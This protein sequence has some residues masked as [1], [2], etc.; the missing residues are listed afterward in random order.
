M[1][2]RLAGILEDMKAASVAVVGDLMLDEYIIGDAE[3][4]SPEAPHP[5]IAERE[6]RSMPGGAAN[7]AVNATALGATVHLFGVIGGDPEGETLCRE[8][9]ARG[10]GTGGLLVMEGR[11]TTRKT[12][13]IAR[14]SQVL[15]VDRET[16]ESIGPEVERELLR[17]ILSAP[18][19]VVVVSD[20]A[21]GL[22]TPGLVSGLTVSGK[23][24]IV[25][26]KSA[27]FGR[28]ARAVLVTP[29]LHELHAAA[30]RKD[31]TPDTLDE[32]GRAIMDA[33]GIANLLVTLGPDGMALIER[34]KP[35]ARIHTRAWEV[36]DV[37]G[38]G[39]TVIAT[40][41]AAVAAGADLADACH[42]ATI[43]SGIVIGK[44]E[45]ATA[46]PEEILAYAFGQSSSDKIVD[47]A[48]LIRRVG[49]L[50]NAGMRIVF[51]NGCFD[52]LHVGHITFL[53]EAR[54]LGD[55]LIVGL[56][57][58]RS[59]RALKGNSRPI[60]PEEERSHVLA[61]LESVSYVVLFD[62][63]TPLDLI[64]AVRPDVLVKGADY[65]REQVVGHDIIESWG[66]TVYLIPL[67]DNA[68]TS[69]IIRRIKESG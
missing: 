36:F 26:P 5:V 41:A 8:L 40:V 22:V 4:V 11:P 1:R 29:N 25:D 43:A 28:Y 49:E 18:C 37:T 67:V 51:T 12:R 35:V 60:I 32:P 7:V 39:D 66:G 61:S 24:V 50:R 34:G 56:N 45:T 15:R 23:R 69:D 2:K 68:S 63:D 42:V 19:D 27:D 53:N 21:K 33:H 31:I 47:R 38:A 20:Y 52:L 9:T 10:V 59:V 13:L 55:I 62:E 48:T 65:A 3:R 44:R 58:D 46:S 14:G 6:R 30:G 64:R 57:T 16:T 17:R 54:G